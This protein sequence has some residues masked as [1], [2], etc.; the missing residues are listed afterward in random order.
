MDY[1]NDIIPNKRRNIMNIKLILSLSIAALVFIVSSEC[2]SGLEYRNTEEGEDKTLS[3]YFAI[4]NGDPSVD[5]FP[6]KKTEVE[7]SIVGV[8][9]YVTVTQTY[10]NVGEKPIN[11]EYIFPASTRAAVHGMTMTIGQH[12]IK[13]K[14]K[15]RQQAKKVFEAAKQEGKSASLLQQQRPNVFSMDI[16]NVMPGD[17]VNIELRYS[18]LLTPTDGIYEFVY[19]TVVGPRYSELTEKTASDHDKWVKNPYLHEGEDS[20]STFNITAKISTGI[21]LNELNCKTHKTDVVWDGKTA[22]TISLA[23]SDGAAGNRDFIL[24]YSTMGKQVQSGLMLY[25][26]KDENFFFLMAQP[27]E[28]VKL[29]DIPPREYIF[30]MD[31]S[32]SM[33]GFPISVSKELLRSLIGGLRSTDTFNVILFAGKSSVM[34]PASV[35]ATKKNILK[36]LS[37]IDDQKGSGGT[38]LISA[39]KEAM[40]MSHDKDTSRSIVIV[41]D[42]YISADKKAFT[43]IK[44]NLNETNVFAFGI[45]TSVN[46]Y[47]I[48]GIARAGKGMPF[49]VTTKGD[50]PSTANKFREYIESPVL[51][52]ITVDYSG[53]NTYSIEPSAIP[54]LMATRPIQI[55]GKWKGRPDGTITIT[56][57]GGTGEYRQ[58]FDVSK[59][60]PRDEHQALKYLWARARVMELS[61][62]AGSMNDEDIREVTTLGLTYDLLTEYTSFVA[63]YEEIRNPEK[64]STDVTQPLPLPEGVSDLA[65]PELEQPIYASS[66]GVKPAPKTVAEPELLIMLT[67]MAVGGAIAFAY[68]LRRRSTGE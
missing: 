12:V 42:G 34:A 9:A 51:T 60:Q 63:V 50:A 19:P 2:A 35:P 3:P 54:D 62:Y 4:E 45:G 56:G 67:I 10:A 30:V 24:R 7:A 46:R 17:V 68:S 22:A 58:T 8:I 15:E 39:L 44:E 32:G 59:T 36:A 11:A 37:V 1:G 55:F 38:R 18:E 40:L 66:V 31:V 65:V 29:E 47:L 64:E 49:V 25:Q 53:F 26:G 23:K 57:V 20:P 28:K 33:N 61:D 52:G 16:A 13:A 14:I 48:E 5:S 21:P 43:M 6:L 41:T 27:P